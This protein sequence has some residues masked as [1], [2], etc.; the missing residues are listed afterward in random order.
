MGRFGTGGYCAPVRDVRGEESA[1]PE[2]SDRRGT[3]RRMDGRGEEH[4]DPEAADPVLPRGEE[5][6][7]MVRFYACLEGDGYTAL[8]RE[9]CEGATL[10]QMTVRQGRLSETEAVDY[11]I[12]LCGILEYLHRPMIHRD[13]KPENLLETPEGRLVLLDFDAARRYDPEKERDTVCMGSK[14]TAAPEQY[15]FCQTDVRSDIYG[16]G[17]TLLYLLCGSY[18]AGRLNRADCSRRLKRT[19]RKAAAFEPE[20]RFREIGEL[21]RELV[22][23][24]RFGAG[25]LG[26]ARGKL[27]LTAALSAAMGAAAAVLALALVWREPQTE[28]GSARESAGFSTVSEEKIVLWF[29][30]ENYREDLDRAIQAYRGRDYETLGNVSRSLIERLYDDPALEARRDGDTSF[31]ESG[32]FSEDMVARGELSLTEKFNFRLWYRDRM[33]LQGLD[34]YPSCG[35]RIAAKM[36]DMLNQAA[37]RGTGIM[38]LYWHLFPEDDTGQRTEDILW[39]YLSVLTSAIFPLVNE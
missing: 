7:G 20:K 8:V 38:V 3:L 34:A 9:Y 19:I 37:T 18:E 31:F 32:E 14:D 25:S 12:R 17:K 2:N 23:C 28:S 35:R 10:R 13:I 6:P 36:D 21:K 30:A 24:R 1:D 27:M 5:T 39:D 22:R 11:G 26:G 33:L 15:G 16:V 4:A 29:D